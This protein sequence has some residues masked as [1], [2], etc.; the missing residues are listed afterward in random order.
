MSNYSEDESS[1]R[2]DFF[3]PSGRW[4]Q[5]IALVWT[6]GYKNCSVHDEFKKSLRNQ[7]GDPMNG[8]TAVCLTPYH[9][10]SHPIMVIVGE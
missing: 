2:V 1:V 7:I 8:M 9:E 5:S 3:K 4:Y 10:H 6:G